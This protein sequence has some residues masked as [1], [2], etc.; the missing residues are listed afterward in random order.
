MVLRIAQ[1]FLR[2]GSFEICLPTDA[3]T[4]RAGPS[5]ADEFPDLIKTLL[6]HTIKTYFPEIWQVRE[7]D[8]NFIFLLRKARLT[9]NL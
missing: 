8:L 7:G 1:T 3:T 2:F 4:G 6:W 9:A 5:P